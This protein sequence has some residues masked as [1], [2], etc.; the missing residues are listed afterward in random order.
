VHHTRR[1]LPD[2]VTECDAIPVTSVARTILDLAEVLP[3]RELQRVVEQ[4]E[5]LHLFDLGAINALLARSARRRGMRALKAALAEIEDEPPRV[6]SDWER[7][8]LDF[9]EDHGL[10]RPELNAMAEGYE[11]DALWREA[12]LVVELDSYS[13]HRSRSAFENDRLKDGALQLAGYRVIR[14]TWRRLANEPKAVAEL[15]SA[16]IA[17]R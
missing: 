13:F 8:F 15:L 1:L 5:R 6:N 4:A 3:P 14:I 16:A 9:C 10:P 17:A 12:K 2:D 11:V 7:D